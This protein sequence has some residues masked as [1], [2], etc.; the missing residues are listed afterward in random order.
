MGKSWP[1]VLHIGERE[2]GRTA[3][4]FVVAEAGVNHNG[5][6]TT[7]IRLVHAAADAGADAIKF[8]AFSADRLVTAAAPAATY[9]KAS[10]QRSMLAQLELSPLELAQVKAECDALGLIFLATP[11]SPRDVANLHGMGVSAIKISS[12]DV[13]NPPLLRIAAAT[14]LPIILSTGASTMDEVERAVDTLDKGGCREL[15]L[16]HCVSTYP[17]PQ[18]ACNLRTVFTLGETFRCPVGFS[19]HTLEPDTATFAVAAGATV[20]EKHFT[21]GRSQ[22]GPDHFFSLEPAELTAYIAAA[23]R[24]EAVLGH[25][26]REPADSEQEV[27]RVARSSV[28]SAQRIAAGTKIERSMLT[29]KRPAGG[30]EPARLDELIGKTAAADI[31]ADTTVRWEMVQ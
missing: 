17:T 24:A 16:L 29:I 14:G 19:D 8:Q 4:V 20:L 26:R 12:P 9:Q 7:A 6:L 23:R 11:F 13:A 30:I 27:R 22:F 10:D 28:V 15:A 21:L 18:N 3:P 25:G 31:P 5:K 1:Q 2:V